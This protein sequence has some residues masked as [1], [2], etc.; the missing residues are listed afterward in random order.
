MLIALAHAPERALSACRSLPVI[1]LFAL[2]ALT[3]ASAAWTVGEPARALRWGVVLGGCA[4]LAIA[5]ATV[6][7]RRR[8]FNALAA[9]IATT[10]AVAAVEGVV[11]V[12]L[13]AEPL[14]VHRAG[15][16]QAAGP[17]EYPPALAWLEI[18]A[19]PILLGAM[20]RGRAAL[21]AL[22][23]SAM[24]LATLAIALSSSRAA[25]GLAAAVL[26]LCAI[27]ER[28]RLR[29]AP[30][31]IASALGLAVGAPLL[32]LLVTDLADPAAA[33]SSDAGR[34]AVLALT[35]VVPGIAWAFI[36]RSLAREVPRPVS[37]SARARLA[38]TVA[39]VAVGV[40]AFAGSALADRDGP[41]VGSSE[42]WSHGRTEVW[43]AAL[44]TFADH[45][46]A[47]VGGDAYLRG[48]RDEQGDD[49]VLYA[50]NL[51]LE[52]AAE[53]GLAGLASVIVLCGATVALAWRRRASE[54]AWLFAP[55]A[56]LFLAVN[57]HDWSWHLA[58]AGAVWALALG[59]LIGAEPSRRLSGGAARG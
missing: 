51:P 38:A 42:G 54:A 5:A 45:P 18:A 6:A 43:E 56:I 28:P 50:H 14:A 24:A 9:I 10:A 2:A 47:G 48:S 34:A 39:A 25:A 15:E 26:V 46:I 29:V 8:G 3:V 7:G 40:A 27:A 32:V 53:L 49:P 58:G 11:A 33:L 57:L 41:A 19:I 22:A 37:L 36:G 13:R 59:A 20:L 21:G 12:A 4:A 23:G 31:R 35:C 16:W 30:V 52:A 44:R 17:F 55:A 1:A